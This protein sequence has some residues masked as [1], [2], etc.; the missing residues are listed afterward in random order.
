MKRSDTNYARQ[1]IQP[2][3]QSVA[4]FTNDMTLF[5]SKCKILI[6][7]TIIVELKISESWI[8]N[9]LII[10]QPSVKREEIQLRSLLV[11]MVSIYVFIYKFKN[12]NHLMYQ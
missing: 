4:V 10:Q 7:S 1:L 11:P 9:T 3:I 6:F 12:M 5:Y 2:R 8:I